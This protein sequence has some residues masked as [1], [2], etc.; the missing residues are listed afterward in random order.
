MKCLSKSLKET[1]KTAEDFLRKICKKKQK[2]ATVVGLFGDLGS[3][4]TAFVQLLAEILGIKE[5]VTSPTFVIMKSY[6]LK[7]KTLNLKPNTLI[8]IDAYRL[9]SGRELLNLGLEETL[10]D[11][12]NLVLIEWPERVPDVLP[13]DLIK[14]SFK[15]IG[16]NEREITF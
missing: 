14:I 7:P 11:S 2:K 16:K 15:F 5:T 12:K 8:H 9:E 4:K 6:S 1:Q 13:K 10:K 3:G